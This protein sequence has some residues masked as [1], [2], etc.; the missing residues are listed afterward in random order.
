MQEVPKETGSSHQGGAFPLD[1]QEQMFSVVVQVADVTKADVKRGG[2]LFWS[3]Q[4]PT[5]PQF[6]N[7][8]TAKFPFKL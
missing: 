1:L 4:Q 3:K 6:V 5:L 7:P 2:A 8:R